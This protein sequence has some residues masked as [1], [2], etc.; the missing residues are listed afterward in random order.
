[1][2]KKIFNRWCQVDVLKRFLIISVICAIVGF[3]VICAFEDWSA[4][5]AHE[6]SYVGLQQIAYSISENQNLN[7]KPDE[8]LQN[9][10]VV[11]GTDGEINVKLHAHDMSYI[12][13]TMNEDYQIQEM[14]RGSEVLG[15]VI[16]LIIAFIGIGIMSAEV[17]FLVYYGIKA[18]CVFIIKVKNDPGTEKDT[19]ISKSLEKEKS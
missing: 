8:T 6:E 19:E 18:L 5:D 16:L 17:I 2:V 1:M 14:Y 11:W 3:G 12:Y 9:Y 13:F 7:L 15:F 10:K 4:W